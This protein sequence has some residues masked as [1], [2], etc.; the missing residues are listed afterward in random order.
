MKVKIRTAAI[1]TMLNS[2]TAR[3]INHYTHKMHIHV[4]GF[5]F[6]LLSTTRPCGTEQ[7][8]SLAIQINTRYS[9]ISKFMVF[10][11]SS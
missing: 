11:S 6:L 10:N 4:E 5:I 7:N 3:N 8:K 1:S 9:I 2:P